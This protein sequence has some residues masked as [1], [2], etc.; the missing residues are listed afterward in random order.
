LTMNP[1]RDT[2]ELKK[3][4][5]SFMEQEETGPITLRELVHAFGVPRAD[6]DRF[7]RIIKSMVSEGLLIKTRGGRYGLPSKMNLVTGRL[8]CHPDGYGFV[9]PEG[10][11]KERE[12]DIFISNRKLSGAMHNDTVVARVEGIKKGGRGDRREGS[13]IRVIS[14]ANKTIVGRFEWGRGFGVVIPS[15]ERVI[16]DIIIPPKEAKGATDG[17]IVSAEITRWPA[18]NMG[19]TGRVLDIIGD[20]DDP[21]VEAEVILR[22]Y[23][24]PNRFPLSVM[25]EVKGVPR[26]VSPKEIKDRVDLRER[27]VFTIDGETAKDFDDAVSIE[28]THKGYRLWVSIADVSYYV[29]EGTEIDTE[30]YAR[31]TSVYFPDRAIPMLP[32]ALSNGICSLNPNV[33]RLTMTAELDL[34]EDG[35]VTHKRFYESVIRSAERMTYT[36]VKKLITDEDAELSKRYA[37]ILPDVKLMAELAQKLMK[38]RS[39]E[40]SIDFD[41]PEP[42]IIIDIEGR[43]EGIVKSERNIAHR[44]IEE[45]MLSANRAVAEEFSTRELPF[46]YRVHEEPSVD[47]IADFAEFVAGFGIRF[48]AEG[49]KSFQSVLKQVEGKAEEKLVNHV[50]LR[51]MKQAVYSEDN[52]GHFGLAFDDYTHFTSPIRRYPDLVVHRLLKLLLKKQYTAEARG[53]M[54]SALPEIAG[55]T[56]A[57]ERK[58][59]E[60]EREI[61]DLKKCQFMKDKVGE[62]Y[63]GFVSG[64][65]SFGFFVELKDY[66]VEGLV[67]VSM[68]TGDYYIFDEKRHTLTGER[69][70]KSFRLA[71]EVRVKVAG[72]DLERRRID[73]VLAQEEDGAGKKK[74]RR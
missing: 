21:D 74:R 35:R 36:D 12:G 2:E 51:S 26:E 47:S 31:S 34:D 30:A 73:L 37:R 28:K 68:L 72:V 6:R 38:R 33:D 25:H 54:E 39:E 29:K 8:T 16:S 57:R 66:F 60:A 56:S 61:A 40:G 10:A 32:E 45:F 67:H 62:E 50:L 53:H 7:K 18:K 19:A 58:A 27:T 64:V 59:M 41:L 14:R 43:V 65:T 63:G 44:L 24:L 69:T 22:K 4:V 46:I 71:D 49:P 48:S 23:G 5:Q 20:P 13:I 70:K 1:E 3:K 9:V 11:G 55:H 52:A 42:Q 15:D 17:M